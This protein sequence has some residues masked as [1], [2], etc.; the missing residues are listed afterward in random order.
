ME[1]GTQANKKQIGLASSCLSPMAQ[2]AYKGDFY[3]TWQENCQKETF[4]RASEG[5]NTVISRKAIK[6]E[7]E[8]KKRPDSISRESQDSAR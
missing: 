2:R 7:E 4:S 8:N 6:M 3:I 5:L 1:C